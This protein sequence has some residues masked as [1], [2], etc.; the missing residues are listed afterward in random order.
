MSKIV[1]ILDAKLIARDGL[2]YEVKLPEDND[3]R[4]FPALNKLVGTKTAGI[5][6]LTVDVMHIPCELLYK[7]IMQNYY[8]LK[9]NVLVKEQNDLVVYELKTDIHIP[10]NAYT[11]RNIDIHNDWAYIAP[12][13][14]SI[15]AYKLVEFIKLDEE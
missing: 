3:F 9:A 4:F 2:E 15:P 7:G 8:E 1:R 13:Q 6:R 5:T 12:L 11:T 10:D 14:I